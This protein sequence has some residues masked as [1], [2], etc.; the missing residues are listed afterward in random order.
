[1]PKINLFDHSKKPFKSIIDMQQDTAY[2]NGIKKNVVVTNTDMATQSEKYILSTEPISRGDIVY[3]EGRYYLVWQ[4]SQ[5]ERYDTYKGMMRL[6]DYDV[7]FDLSQ[8]TSNVPEAY[9]VKAQVLARDTSDATIAT[10]ATVAMTEIKAEIHIWLKDNPNTRPLRDLRGNK[11]RFLFGGYAWNILHVS[12]TEKGFLNITARIDLDKA[13]DKYDDNGILDVTGK[14]NFLDTSLYIDGTTGGGGEEPVNLP[15]SS[16][17]TDI[18]MVSYNP[19]TRQLVWSKPTATTEYTGFVG[20]NLTVERSLLFG[21]VDVVRDVLVTDDTDA[22]SY[23]IPEN[24]VGESGWYVHIKA[25]WS[26]GTTTI[27]TQEQKFYSPDNSVP[28]EQ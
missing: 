28:V 11:G 16:L 14:E 8:L 21:E 15:P 5:V 4:Q 7:I 1:M 6:C 20:Y 13:E 9:L 12:R 2:I 18:G 10:I 26:D 23:I 24:P 17:V 22:P 25:V 3:Y 19:T 27:M